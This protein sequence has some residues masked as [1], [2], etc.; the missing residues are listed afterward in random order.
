MRITD[1]HPGFIDWDTYQA[2]QARIAT[3]TRP[4]AHQPGTGAVR[5]GCALLQGLATYGV[6][7]RKLAVYYEGP[8]KATPGYYCTAGGLVNGRGVFHMRIGGIAIQTAA[9]DT[10]LAALA[11]ASLQACLAAA[12]QLE[13]GHDAALAQWRREVERA[14]YAAAKTERRY[15]AVDPDNRL[16]ARGLEAAW[17]AASATWRRPGTNWPAGKQPGPRH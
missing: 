13:D 10:F 12:Q 8:T 16:V 1:H 7:G 14:R 15:Q 2:N 9:T 4:K 3:N 5:E 17:E 6:C 11:P